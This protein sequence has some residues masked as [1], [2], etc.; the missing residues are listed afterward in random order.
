ME[1]MKASYQRSQEYLQAVVEVANGERIKEEF[2]KQLFLVAGFKFEEAG[3]MDVLD[4]QRRVSG[5]D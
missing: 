1:V 4:R 3:K 5:H 2:K